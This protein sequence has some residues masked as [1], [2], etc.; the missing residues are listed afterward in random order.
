MAQCLE[1]LFEQKLL[2]MPIEVCYHMY[3]D[4][5]AIGHCVII[6]ITGI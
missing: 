3:S 6:I 5:Y 1:R 4:N 2:G